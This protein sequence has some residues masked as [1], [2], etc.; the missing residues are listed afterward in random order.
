MATLAD[1]LSGIV[2]DTK[3]LVQLCGAL[4][5][6]NAQIKMEVEQLRLL[7]QSTSL[8]NQQLAEKLKAIAVARTFEGSGEVGETVINEKILDTKRKINDFVREID[9]CIELLK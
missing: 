2:T 8:E 4:K 1:K 7:V 6:E 5:S 9:K 3:Q